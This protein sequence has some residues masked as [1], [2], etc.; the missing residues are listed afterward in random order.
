MFKNIHNKNKDCILTYN[1]NELQSPCCPFQAVRIQGASCSTSMPPPIRN[2]SEREK[3]RRRKVNLFRKADQLARIANSQ[4][5]VLVT[6][7]NLCYTYSST[8]KDFLPPSFVSVLLSVSSQLNLQATRFQR[9]ER[10]VPQDYYLKKED[11]EKQAPDTIVTGNDDE[12]WAVQPPLPA[13]TRPIN[14]TKASVQNSIMHLERNDDGYIV[15]TFSCICG[16]VAPMREDKLYGDTDYVSEPTNYW[17]PTNASNILRPLFKRFPLGDECYTGTEWHDN[18]IDKT[19]PPERQ[20]QNDDYE[21]QIKNPFYKPI[22]R[23]L[24]P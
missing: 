14:E 11:I 8:G 24:F 15:S 9:I 7:N 22:N 23:S 12:I 18:Y 21:R 16:Q 17:D 4:M 5:C 6:R 10:K 13:A 19:V 1:V 3:F 20:Y 2:R